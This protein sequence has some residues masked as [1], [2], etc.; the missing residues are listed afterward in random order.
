MTDARTAWRELVRRWM[1]QPDGPGG[2]RHWAPEVE[3]APRERLRDIQ[4][5]KLGVLVRYLYGESP[6]YRRLF[7]SLG[8]TP[9]DIRSVDDLRKVPVLT[10]EELA[11]DQA[12]APPWGT[13]PPITHEL[14]SREGWLL[15]STSGTTAMP[16]AFRLTRHDRDL[17]TWLYCRAFY[18]GGIRG[19]HVALN[20]FS[21]GPFSA[22]WG[23]HLALNHMG[24]PVIPGGGMDTK[25][26]ATF[27]GHYRPTILICT[28]SYS[29]F[30]GE[31][32]RQMGHEPSTSGVR[33]LITAGEP[34]PCIP[35]TKVRIES[36]WNAQ[37]VDNYGSTEVA[38][39]PLA[40][41]CREEAQ[42]RDRPVNLHLTEDLYVPE[43][44]DPETWEPV[45]PGERGVMVCTNLWSEGQPYLRYAIGDYLTVGT[46]GCECGRTHAHVIGGFSG[47]PDDM[48]KVRGLV[49]FP[50]TIEAVVRQVP[51]LT[52]EFMLVLTTGAGGLDELTVQVEAGAHVAA[53]RYGE[54]GERV[55]EAI[56]THVG[57]RAEVEVLAPATLPRT[58]FKARR[59]T[60]RRGKPATPP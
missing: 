45:A 24:S 31:T 36:L 7:D 25:R 28:P 2:E 44:L 4:E 49:L 20:C 11:R 55:R 23:A 15:T 51:D 38:P 33:F 43:V 21:Y 50:S 26:R 12:E 41:T 22:F 10:K 3:T 17:L 59:L 35:A 42:H 60:D 1:V 6:Y 27:I 57:L 52:N 54:L 19:G 34:G 13:A 14:W 8:L 39:A 56:R 37:I 46:E 40:Y 5:E 48:V 32:M 30:L 16:R 47:R 18:A 58:E 29:L 9:A 53:A